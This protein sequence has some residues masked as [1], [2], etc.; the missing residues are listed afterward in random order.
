MVLGATS[1]TVQQGLADAIDAGRNIIAGYDADTNCTVAGGF[2]L[3]D[4]T[5]LSNTGLTLSA[6]GW[7][8]LVFP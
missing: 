8:D 4:Q 6:N 7:A 2:R 3:A 1:A 5:H